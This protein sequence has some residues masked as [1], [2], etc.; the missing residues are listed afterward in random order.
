MY[1]NVL[2]A[3]NDSPAAERAL[4]RAI[5]LAEN[6][7]RLYTLETHG[8]NLKPDERDPWLND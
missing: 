2:I 6:R 8:R 3:L 4:H 1:K 7:I 5:A